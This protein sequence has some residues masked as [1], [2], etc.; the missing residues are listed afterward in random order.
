[1]RSLRGRV[2]GLCFLL[3]ALGSPCRGKCL[4]ALM[5]VFCNVT[6]DFLAML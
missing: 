6:A 3:V 4:F 2:L 5:L 1:M